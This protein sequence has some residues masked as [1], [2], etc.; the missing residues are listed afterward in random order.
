MKTTL[1]RGMGR[2]AAVN[3]NGRPVFPPGILTPMRR[4]RQPEPPRRTFLQ[5]A[6]RILL[7]LLVVAVMTGGGVAG[8]AYLYYHQTAQELAPHSAAVKKATEELAKVP[9][10]SEPANAL[11]IG[12]DKRAGHDPLAAGG[13][14]SDTIMLVRA[15]P[16]D[17]TISMLSFPRDLLVPIYCKGTVVSSQER[18]NMAW[19]MCGPTGTLETVQHLTGVPIHYIV[20][21]DFHGF[22]LIVNRLG[23]VWIDVDHRY[24]IP[25]HTGTS[26]IDLQPGYA[27]LNG[28]EA[29]EFVRFRHTDSDLY[30]LA[31]QQEF[32]QALKQRIS[33]NFSL[34]SLPKIV[35]AIKGS[36]EIG[37]GGGGAIPPDVALSYAHFAYSLPSGGF[38]RVPIENLAGYNTLTAPQ[39]AIDAAVQNFLHPD[40]AAAA[41]ANAAALGRKYQAKKTLRPAQISTLVLNGTTVPGLATNTS[42]ELAQQGYHTVSL[43]G[44]ARPNAPTSGYIQTQIYYN[45]GRSDG[46]L[47]AQQLRSVL[48]PSTQIAPLTPE[49][50]PY[51]QQ[52]GDPLTVVV[53]GSSFDGKLHVAAQPTDET[54]KHV[55]PSVVTNVGMT[56]AQLRA[57]AHRVPF[58]V[59][60]PHVIATQSQL[61]YCGAA[62][63][64]NAVRVYKPAPFRRGVRV[65]F[66]WGPFGNEYWGIEETDFN[67]APVL[68]GPSVAHTFGSRKF[69][70]YY[71]GSHLH[72]IV[73]H[74]G[75]AT[76]WVVN[77]LLDRLSNETM[78]AIARGLKPLG[79]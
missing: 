20:T 69:D 55:R 33:G 9:S 14:R 54:P 27:K 75:N 71:S 44:Q 7:W 63:K 24:Y 15:N 6:G 36:V 29:L 61:E 11:I 66:Q 4:Y 10:A 70:F 30:R 19:S 65:T 34:T 41:K 76:Y 38:R 13:S 50:L 48:G 52:S 49:F 26:A 59:E 53:L 28:G 12:Y 67:D 42:F 68:S 2:A 31:R 8:G 56:L 73:L 79:Q 58:T 32:V 51:A 1:K 72:M 5:L 22:K 46:K 37:R 25:P 64:C 62:P 35:G 18:I 43:S 45:P 21:V 77:T 78:I 60:V 16:H 40:L 74:Q 47:A 39:S 3:G 57:A 23:G 17:H